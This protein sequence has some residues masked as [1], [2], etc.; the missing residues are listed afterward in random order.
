MFPE[1]GA[2]R[3]CKMTG[4]KPSYETDAYGWAME[5][6]EKIR[7][8]RF[9]EITDWDNIAEEIESVG[10]SERSELRSFLEQVIIHLLKWQFQPEKRGRS[11]RLSIAEHRRRAADQLDENPSLKPVLNDL[12][13]QAFEL[14][15]IRAARQTG[16]SLES[17]FPEICPYTTEQILSDDWLPE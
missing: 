8:R 12:V 2:G 6:A 16:L 4:M 10:K 13:S 17:A 1:T 3:L 11:W 9:D 14:A 5:T 7:S 15:R